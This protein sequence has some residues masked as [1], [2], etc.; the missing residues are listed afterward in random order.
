MDLLD[1]FI[2][3][4]SLAKPTAKA[5]KYKLTNKLF[6]ERSGNPE[7][8]DV[9]FVYRYIAL[10]RHFGIY[11]GNNKVIHFAAP[12]GDFDTEKAYIHETTLSHFSEGSD[13]HIMTFNEDYESGSIW[14]NIL[15]SDEFKN[16]Y[17]IKGFFKNYL[18]YI[19]TYIFSSLLYVIMYIIDYVIK[20]KY[21]KTLKWIFCI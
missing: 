21:S 6:N 7:Y 16:D 4:Y 18:I 12:N 1:L 2:P 19:G 10:Y 15:K 5:I 8:G 14:R 9:I 20:I 3:G 13:I 17:E 11:I